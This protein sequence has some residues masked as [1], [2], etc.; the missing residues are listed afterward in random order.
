MADDDEQAVSD[1]WASSGAM[2]LTGRRDGPALGPPAPLVPRLLDLGAR[3]A[4]HSEQLG[5]CVDVDP[6][7]LL[8]ERAAIANLGRRGQTSCGGGTRLL[9]TGDG[10]IAASLAR[11]TDIES[12]PAW[13][14]VDPLEPDSDP[15]SIAETAVRARSNADLVEQAVLLGMPVAALP[16]TNRMPPLTP[17]GLPCRAVRLAAGGPIPSLDGVLVVDLTSLW[18]GPLCGSLLAD[19]GATVVKVESTSRPDGARRGPTDFFDLLNSGKR[20]VALDLG[21]ESGPE[22]LRALLERSD[23]I[24]EASRPRALEQLGIDAVALLRQA[25]PR[26]WISITGYGRQSPGRDRV[27]FGDDA[28]VGGG[29]VVWEHQ[30]PRFC[31]DAIADPTTGLVAAVAALDA[32]ASGGSWLVDVSMADVAAFLAG[33]TVT[34][35]PST[36]VAPAAVR[37]ISGA[38]APLGA[39]TATVLRELGVWA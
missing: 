16:S 18:A 25:A 21:G 19:A 6:L 9:R 23:V 38:A 8:S 22:T 30:E 17:S 31:A 32:L 33:P 12:V 7:A 29:L 24:L 4:R 39:D 2:A 5:R 1:A 10:W 3:L 37:R 20:S 26:A 34:A 27:A 35:A 28:A 11:P 14:E 36:P 13:L 15:W